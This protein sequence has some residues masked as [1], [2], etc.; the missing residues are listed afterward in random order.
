MAKT[1]GGAGSEETVAANGSPTL[2]SRVQSLAEQ[3]R[4]DPGLPV[5]NST[6]AHWQQPPDRVSQHQSAN[7]TEDTDVLIIGSG[8]T[9]CG[10][11]KRLLEQ[12]DSLR[13]TILEARNITSG[14]TGRNGG[15][16]KAV[17]EIS[18]SDLLPKV[19]K[20]KAQE[21]VHFTLRNVNELLGLAH[22]LPD[23]QREYS[24]VRAVETLNIFTD[25]EGFAH[26]KEIVSRFDA[27]N[28]DLKGRARIIERNEL[29]EVGM[30]VFLTLH[31]VVDC[32]L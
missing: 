20:V 18:Y 14:A 11:A 7:L 12:S 27:D 21:V 29:L 26:A 19:G 32:S 25:E 23:K 1:N 16:I 17:P 30:C 28:P 24:E 15:H 3:L 22:S 9:A 2:S 4:Q 8:I 6:Q 5:P 13:V 10:V 31:L